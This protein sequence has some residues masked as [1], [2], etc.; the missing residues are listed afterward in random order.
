[1]IGVSKVNFVNIV[2]KYT[3]IEKINGNILIGLI[4]KI[5]KDEIQFRRKID[6]LLLKIKRKDIKL[7]TNEKSFENNLINKE[8]KILGYTYIEKLNGV[9]YVGF[10]EKINNE[11]IYFRKNIDNNIIKIKRKD[12]KNIL[13]E[14]SF[15]DKLINIKSKILGYTYIKLNKGKIYEGF[16]EKINE[17]EIYFRNKNDNLIIKIKK[18]EINLIYNQESYKK[19]F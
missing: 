13:N 14:K 10:I 18:E 7:I 4:E 19:R 11:E 6:H 3:Y 12:V 2:D 1:M 16:I 5:S 17:K 15:N 9:I 8:N